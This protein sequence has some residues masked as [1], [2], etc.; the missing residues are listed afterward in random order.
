MTESSESQGKI[1]SKVAD[2]IERATRFDGSDISA[3]EP[4]V[5]VDGFVNFHLVQRAHIKVNVKKTIGRLPGYADD[6]LNS[7]AAEK[8]LRKR[9]ANT[10]TKLPDAINRWANEDDGSYLRLLPTHIVKLPKA[11]GHEWKCS[12]CCGYGLVNC[13]QCYSGRVQCYGCYGRRDVTCNTCSGRGKRNCA[14]CHGSGSVTQY[15]NNQTQYVTCQSCYGSGATSCYSCN[16]S[17]RVACNNCAGRGDLQCPSC[18]GTMRVMCSPCSGAG[19]F[20]ECGHFDIEIESNRHNHESQAIDQH[21]A[22]LMVQIAIEDLPQYGERVHCAHDVNGTLIRT[23]YKFQIPH[24]K[25]ELQAAQQRFTIYG[26]GA[27]AR[28]FDYQNIAG[29]MLQGDLNVLRQSL[30]S[31]KRSQF[32]GQADVLDALADFTRSELN[33]V[34]AEELTGAKPSADLHQA[35]EAK[36]GGMVSSDYIASASQSFKSAISQVYRARVNQPTFSLIGIAL[37]LSAMLGILRLPTP[38]WIATGMLTFIIC[39]VLWV[40]AETHAQSSIA[41]HF[42]GVL[43]KRIL[44]MS[45][46]ASS[47][48]GWSRGVW[49]GLATCSFGGAYAVFYLSKSGTW[50]NDWLATTL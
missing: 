17:G 42:E 36:F 38:N 4:E 9:L 21:S 50:L 3:A 22:N 19:W 2:Y 46:Q 41:R 43:G 31:Y 26:F 1:F 35:V 6:M 32:G 12:P 48:K 5:E 24:Q 28:V 14:S 39:G 33:M 40:L 23:S 10:K 49:L 8:E 11:A 27:E 45:K 18:A 16:S 7:A 20:N 30:V 25:A 34:I 15:Y 37:M 44:E 13:T 47:I 29:H